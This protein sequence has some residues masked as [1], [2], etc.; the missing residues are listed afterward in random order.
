M[1]VQKSAQEYQNEA[2]LYRYLDSL[3]EQALKDIIKELLLYGNYQIIRN[4]VI[5]FNKMYP[6][7]T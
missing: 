4:Q 3:K 6:E 2:K 5:E 1:N 7:F